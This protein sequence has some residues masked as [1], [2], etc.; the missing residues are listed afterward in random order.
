MNIEDLLRGMVA[1]GASDL[2][3]KAGSPPGYRI[4]G[5]VVAQN[6]LGKLS[7]DSTQNLALQLMT[8]EQYKRF[9]NDGDLDFSYALKD[10]ARFRVNALVQRCSVSLVCRQIPDTI[11]SMKDLGLPDVCT[12]LA[13]KPRGL[14][15]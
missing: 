13:S 4:D 7:P 1:A 15:L 2:H 3:I 12:E 5:S 14:V 6:Q 9:R 11:P 8:Q 10:V